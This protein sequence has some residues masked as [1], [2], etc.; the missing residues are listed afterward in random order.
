MSSIKGKEIKWH[1]E[2]AGNLHDIANAIGLYLASG[3][4][5][6]GSFVVYI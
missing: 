1:D 6:I 3:V 4:R 2:K 5:V